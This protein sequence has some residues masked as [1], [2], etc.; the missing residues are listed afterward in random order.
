[1]GPSRS[2]S[3]RIGDDSSVVVGSERARDDSNRPAVVEPRNVAG[4]TRF[5]LDEGKE[6]INL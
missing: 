6:I 1:M 2:S 5:P 3:L 4:A